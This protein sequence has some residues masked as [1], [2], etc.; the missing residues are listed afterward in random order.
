MTQTGTRDPKLAGTS[1]GM[2]KG[3]K[4]GFYNGDKRVAA[5][6]QVELKFWIPFFVH[7]LGNKSPLKGGEAAELG[8]CFA[9]PIHA[10]N[11]KNSSE[12][13]GLR[14]RIEEVR[15]GRRALEV[16]RR[17]LI[18]DGKGIAIGN[19]SFG[20]TSGGRWTITSDAG[21]CFRVAPEIMLNLASMVL[22]DE[23]VK[24]NFPEYHVDWL[25]S[26]RPDLWEGDQPKRDL[27]ELREF[28]DDIWEQPARPEEIRAS[29]AGG[30]KSKPSAPVSV[31]LDQQP[32]PSEG[33]DS[34][35]LRALLNV[36]K[37]LP[38]LGKKP[39]LGV[40]AEPLGSLVASAVQAL[41]T[42]GIQP[43]P[44]GVPA[45]MLDQ[46][47]E[48][49]FK[50]HEALLRERLQA[51][52][53]KA[54]EAKRLADANIESFKVLAATTAK[55][56]TQ[57]EAQRSVYEQEKREW[58]QLVLDQTND[59]SRREDELKE[60]QRKLDEDR[61]LLDAARTASAR[62]LLKAMNRKKSEE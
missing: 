43:A 58:D 54:E 28:P 32:K 13:E 4:C 56:V 59:L 16:Q 25:P 41:K 26:L 27:R 46:Q 51:E 38:N 5:V 11:E 10:V 40:L 7:L 6:P 60:A 12:V 36:E 18:L 39:G 44:D 2:L 62:D 48:L 49:L 35:L 55:E 47:A 24:E 30:E 23:W 8:R 29:V 19:I 31:S 17:K 15:N 33:G 61:V 21:G 1:F 14:Y 34:E 3:S 53:A 52:V 45:A 22:R 57:A 20:E 50:K 9:V 37:Y 42:L